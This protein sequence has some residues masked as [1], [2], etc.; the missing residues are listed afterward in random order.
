MRTGAVARF[1]GNN[2]LSLRPSER[3]IKGRGIRTDLMTKTM[4]YN[5]EPRQQEIE[6][7]IRKKTSV[8]IEKRS[9]CLVVSSEVESIY[10]RSKAFSL[11]L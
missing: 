7:T 5:D 1:N 3:G 9:N 8:T 11:R 4:D 10:S 2:N 6:V